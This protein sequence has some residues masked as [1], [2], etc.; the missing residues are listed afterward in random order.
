[1]YLI[2]VAQGIK[3]LSY[4]LICV[5]VLLLWA[6]VEEGDINNPRD[7]GHVIFLIKSLIVLTVLVILIP[8]QDLM[9][10]WSR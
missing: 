3:I 2:E 1:M 10:L 6:L 8:S 9:L 7:K 5:S 4:I